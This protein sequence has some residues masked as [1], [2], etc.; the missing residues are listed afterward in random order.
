MRSI[1][2]RA[3]SGRVAGR[4]ASARAIIIP[5]LAGALQVC[6]G[7]V[8]VVVRR[9]LLGHIIG[10]HSGQCAPGANVSGMG[11]DMPI[12]ILVIY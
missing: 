5:G 1:R 6:R 10:P 8:G 3:I 2:G 12:D 4:V 9:G 7:V 11:L